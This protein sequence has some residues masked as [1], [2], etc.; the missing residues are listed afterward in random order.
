MLYKYVLFIVVELIVYEPHLLNIFFRS[1]IFYLDAFYAWQGCFSLY[2]H[3]CTSLFRL[4]CMR[5][6][7]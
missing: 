7:I 5:E 4:A 6:K 1:P 3:A 2:V